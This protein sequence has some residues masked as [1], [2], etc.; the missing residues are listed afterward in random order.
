MSTL[1]E[2]LL[3]PGQRAQACQADAQTRRAA[4]KI[5]PPPVLSRADKIIAEG[6]A[7]RVAYRDAHPGAD[8]AM[9]FGAQIGHLHGEV[10]R[11]CAELAAFDATRSPGLEYREVSTR[12]GEVIVG[13]AY[14][15]DEPDGGASQVEVR[16]VWCNGVDLHAWVPGDELDRIGDEVLER[17]EAAMRHEAEYGMT[18]AED[19]R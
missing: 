8:L 4:D 12:I 16:E 18:R 11:L 6:N 19:G 10:K 15:P 9:V 2:S 3:T 7:K 13:Y 1:L 5:A 17:H 14:L